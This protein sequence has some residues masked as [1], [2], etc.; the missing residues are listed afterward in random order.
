MDENVDE[1]WFPSITHQNPFVP[2]KF[3]SK[4]F[5]FHGYGG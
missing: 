5:C 3:P 4:S 1:K 2:I